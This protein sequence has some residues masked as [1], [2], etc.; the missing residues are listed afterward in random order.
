MSQASYIAALL[1]IASGIAGLSISLYIHHKKTAREVLICP[2]GSNCTNVIHSDYSRFFGIPLEFL[3]IL[4]YLAIVVWYSSLV[5][6]PSLSTPWV[7]FIII[8]TS[9]AAFLFSLYLTFIQ[10]FV[11]RQWCTWCLF[12]ATL[13]TIIF[14]SAIAF[15]AFKFLPFLAA[16]HELFAGIHLLGAAL[17]IGGATI[18]DVL[19][20]KFLKDFRIS[21]L[22]AG[23]LHNVSQVIWFGLA[24][25]VLSGVAL[26][27]P[28]MEYYSTSSKFLLKM[29][30]V[31][32]IIVNGA[33][34]NLLIAP[35]L[36]KL[37]FN[38][39]QRRIFQAMHRTRRIAFALGAISAT[40]WYSAFIL[41][42]LR[43]IPLPLTTLLLFYAGLLCLAM[44]GSQIME[45]F[46]VKKAIAERVHK[47]SIF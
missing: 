34:L 3:G 6:F 33:F 37:S 27:L 1:I 28:E 10:A 9:A 13:C 24:I 23:V 38:E 17:G 47:N 41:G 45:R 39:D 43:S 26:Y 8:T 7:S 36:V 46:F 30:V 40:S 21:K 4:Y 29:I 12:S 20:F 31:G 42:L 11:L 25:L 2:I 32:I 44:I 18:A 16:N 5:S 14:L 35:R 22:E 19:F 15:S